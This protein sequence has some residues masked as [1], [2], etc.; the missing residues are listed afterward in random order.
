MLFTNRQLVQIQKM[1]KLTNRELQIV[2]L[3][4]QGVEA[5]AEL[6]K[7]L[8]L[9][10]HTLKVYLRNIY[11]KAGRNSKVALIVGFAEDVK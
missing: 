5:N 1:Y 11:M 8:G 4:A 10:I 3:L 6:A 2:K 9:S 7:T